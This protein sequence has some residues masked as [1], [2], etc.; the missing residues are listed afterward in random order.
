MYAKAKVS[1]FK[2]CIYFQKSFVLTNFFYSCQKNKDFLKN[3]VYILH[4]MNIQ[5]FLFSFLKVKDKQIGEEGKEVFP[6]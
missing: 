4:H 2:A 6:E 3:K 1:E 5:S